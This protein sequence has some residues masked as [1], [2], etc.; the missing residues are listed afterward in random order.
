MAKMETGIRRDMG[1]LGVSLRREM[2]EMGAS[3]HREMAS[4]RVELL[5]RC[6]LFW[7]G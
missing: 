4:G 1:E 5:K 7:I 6:F 3:L 2:A